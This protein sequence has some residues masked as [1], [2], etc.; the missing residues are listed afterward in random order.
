MVA[1]IL[2]LNGWDGHFL[3]ANTPTEDMM[4][5]IQDTKPDFVG[6]LLYILSNIENLKRSMEAIDFDFPNLGL[7]IGGQAFRWG[8]RYGPPAPRCGIPGDTR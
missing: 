4:Q 8:D 3:G 7:L 2:E 5:F 1:D 6:L